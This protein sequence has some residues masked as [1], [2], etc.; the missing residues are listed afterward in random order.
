[1]RRNRKSDYIRVQ[2]SRE[3]RLWITTV[4]VTFFGIVNFLETHPELKRKLKDK[5]DDVLN[6]FRKNPQITYYPPTK[7]E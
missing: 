6:R 1:M 5:A 2:Q 7:N 4:G 3:V